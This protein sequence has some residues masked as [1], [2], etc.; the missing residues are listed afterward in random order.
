MLAI[1]LTFVVS[2]LIFKFGDRINKV[3]G[4]TGSLVVTRVMGLFLG[5]IAVNFVSV[6]MWNIYKSLV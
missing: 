4:I 2:Y 6:G 3:L 1:L 5:A